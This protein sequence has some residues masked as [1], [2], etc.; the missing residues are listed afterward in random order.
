M[1]IN[2]EESYNIVSRSLKLQH[3]LGIIGII[4]LLSF[5]WIWRT[6]SIKNELATLL[7][8][9]VERDIHLGDFRN[10]IINLDRAGSTLFS[11][12]RLLESD[13]STR[14]VIS[15]PN[16]QTSSKGH[17][18]TNNSVGN[19]SVRI[20]LSNSSLSHTGSALIFKFNAI[21]DLFSFLLS[22][23]P[24]VFLFGIFQYKR[25]LARI[26][27]NLEVVSIQKT[28]EAQIVLASQIAHDIRSPLA[29]LNMV[30]STSKE[31]PEDVRLI[32]RSAVQ[33]INDIANGL[34]KKSKD[35]EKE[36]SK[37]QP[38]SATVLLMALVDSMISEK[39]TQ[40]R[41]KINISI[42]SASSNGYGL[43]GKINPSEL[44]RVI[45]NLINN[46]VEAF[47]SSKGKVSVGIKNNRDKIHIWIEDNGKGIP[48][49]IL[50]KLGQRG[51]TYGK[52][53]S[54]SG[55]GIGVFHAQTTLQS[56]G[57]EFKIESTV[58][59]G[60]IVTLILPK[61]EPPSWFLEK[62]KID[63]NQVVVSVDDDKTIH[64]IWSERLSLSSR[65]FQKS[66]HIKFH[67]LVE[68]EIWV[69]ENHNANNLYLIDYEFFG[70]NG[71]GL[72]MVEKLQIQNQTALVT[73]RF[74]DIQIQS[75]AT[76]LSL[77]ILP[78]SLAHIVPIEFEVPNESINVSV[79]K[80]EK[81]SKTLYD[82]ILIDDDPLMYQVWQMSAEAQD[83]QFL[84]FSNAEDFFKNANG[85]DFDTPIMIDVSLAN[86][87]RGEDI[88]K[89]VISLGFKVVYLTTGFEASSI[90][91]PDGL[92]DVIGKTPF[93]P[94][95]NRRL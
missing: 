6:I 84:Y 45:S 23:T 36:M 87:V 18:T 60:T 61:C 35:Q 1:N 62:I 27:E 40:Y 89:K 95:K 70:Q 24:I 32:M 17:Q 30:T 64:Q 94:G 2:L 77:K 82:V 56:M 33:R 8:K 58:G 49:E 34:L 29:A 80:D 22:M 59:V 74:E 88:A 92:V 54:E 43:F 44:S 91:K 37:T 50:S 67:S 28:A 51:I 12:I 69:Q 48:P 86:G 85:Y 4:F 20:P 41:E 42:E 55:F 38:R 75:K 25:S 57:G 68:F 5:G 72:D 53:N 71:T 78:K 16:S 9:S 79:Q 46:S 73:S 63:S 66:N 76:S 39:Q 19:H 15:G 10:T 3:I 52:E 26:N 47:E 93:F 11:E 14:F 90:K 83:K 31:F 21:E 7:A 13:Q 81:S 65:N